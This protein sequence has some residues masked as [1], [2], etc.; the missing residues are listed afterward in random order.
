[1]IVRYLGLPAIQNLPAT[2]VT[3]ASAW[4]N[5]TITSIGGSPIT[6]VAV[7]WGATDG[8]DPTSGL[9]S[10]TNTPAGGPWTNGAVATCQATGLTANAFYYYRYYATNS[11]GPVWAAASEHFLAGNVTV[12]NTDPSAARNPVGPPDTGMLTIQRDPS[13]TNEALTVYYAWGGTENL[14]VDYTPSLAGTNVT[15]PAGV[16]STNITITPL[17]SPNGNEGQTVW[18]TLLPGEY[19]IGSPASNVVTIADY[20]YTAGANVTT[21]AGD[22]NDGAIWSLKRRPLAGDDVTVTNAVALSNSTDILRSFTISNNATLTF[23]NWNTTLSATDV[24]IYGT[25]THNT[26]TAT[27]APW[28]PDNRVCIVCTNLFVATNGAINADAKG[29]AGS[30][31]NGYGPGGALF[32][33]AGGSYGGVGGSGGAA[34]DSSQWPSTTYGL[35]DCPTNPGSGGGGAGGTSVT[36]TTGGGAIWIQAGA[37]T[38]NGRISANAAWPA[39][40]N[41]G[42]SGGSVWIQC[43]TFTGTNGVV[44]ANAGGPGSAGSAGGVG[45][46]GGGGGRIAIIYDTTAQ[47]ALPVPTVRFSAAPVLDNNTGCTFYQSDIGTLYFPDNRFLTECTNTISHVGQWI[48]PASLTSW[49]LNNLVLSNAWLRIAGSGLQI[50]VTNNVNIVGTYQGLN[51]VFQTLALDVSNAVLTCGGNLVVNNAM[52]VVRRGSTN[53][54]IS[55]GG[56]MILTNGAYLYVYSGPTNVATINY[57]AQVNVTGNVNINSNCWIYPYSDPNNGGSVYFQMNNL[58]IATNAGFNADGNGYATLLSSPGSR[59]YGPGGGIS[60]VLTNSTYRGGGGG[61]GGYGGLCMTVGGTNYGWT[62]GSSTA[63]LDPGS[64]GGARNGSAAG[65]LGG[66]LVRINARG[67]VTLNGIIT[68]NG[69]DANKYTCYSGAGSGGGIYLICRK[70]ASSGCALSAKGGSTS[71]NS[72]GGSGG[73]GGRIAV[74]YNAIATNAVTTSVAG[75]ISGSQGMLNSTGTVGTV[76]WGQRP[77]Q[78]TMILVR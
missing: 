33:Y 19:G 21:N 36:R 45:Y 26:N 30:P 78:G 38:V 42:G 62:Y 3:A 32:S 1:M 61:Y 49:S 44:L 18:L 28:V 17:W 11:S 40:P 53:T 70:F 16:A 74:W 13:A 64:G 72:G 46:E 15:L 29:Y 9:W 8:G 69:L 5:G 68:A 58:M 23:K 25:I 66:G 34:D 22:W 57:G 50:N 39:Q 4:L 24:T 10:A 47:S 41:G 20:P 56:D 2:N 51:G 65:T 73:G 71:V 60:G 31:T 14:N 55:C 48:S 12:T 59:G 75:G 37:V 77:S 67:T 6:A 27:V 76:V 54:A 52:F 35:A 43:R 7:Y 63:P